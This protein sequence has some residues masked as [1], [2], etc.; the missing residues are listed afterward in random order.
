MPYTFNP[1]SGAFDYYQA[2]TA[3][4]DPI[5]NAWQTANDHHANWDTAY[6]W[7][8][9][10][11]AGYCPTARTLT[12]NGTAYDLTANRSWTI[13]AGPSLGTTTQIPYM[14][15]GGTDF[16]YAAGFTFDGTNL[17]ASQINVSG[18]LRYMDATTLGT[19][20]IFAGVNAAVNNNGGDYNVAIGTNALRYADDAQHMVAIGHSAAASGTTYDPF[21][22]VAIGYEAA[23]AVR[24]AGYFVAIGESALTR[25]T[26]GSYNIAIGYIA[27]QNI[28]DGQY[29]LCVGTQAGEQITSGYY[30]IC[31]GTQT[32][33]K[34]KTG[35][36]NTYVG[37]SAGY[38]TNTTPN[39]QLYNTALGASALYLIDNGGNG[40]TAIGYQAG[41][42]ITTGDYNVCIG[43]NIDVPSATANYQVNIANI[44]QG[45]YTPA[46]EWLGLLFDKPF[47][48]G[49]GKDA[50]I[51][52]DGT[53]L[54]INP[55]V[56]GTGKLDIS[57]VLQT[58]GYNAVDGSA[59][60]SGSF[61]TVDLKTVTVK[62]G[63]ITAI[64]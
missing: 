28:T 16:L 8:N 46:S 41:D 44:F 36:Y 39:A 55:K 64:V 24:T 5:F 61:T 38:G 51:T 23:K 19:S 3:E 1:L 57:G 62:D 43:Y 26:T 2:S 15:A 13:A 37:H 11:S 30:N 60:V 42:S 6:G 56:V 58:D 25:V 47:Y 31:F 45:D 63:L 59:G 20:N 33:I 18:F 50:T 54:I 21:W 29:N 4:T 14:N 27:G 52:Y 17:V 10:A 12:I 32:G 48:F 7:G 34:N 40:N 9:H 49:V 22:S 35:S 53:D